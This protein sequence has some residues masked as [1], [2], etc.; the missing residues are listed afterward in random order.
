MY[1]ITRLLA[2][3]TKG[4]WWRRQRESEGDEV[5]DDGGRGGSTQ[6]I[7]E[8][9]A[10]NLRL[11]LTL[12]CRNLCELLTK[13]W[14]L[15]SLPYTLPR[16]GHPEPH[17]PSRLRWRVPLPCENQPSPSTNPASDTSWDPQRRRR[18][19]FLPRRECFSAR[20]CEWCFYV[21][22]YRWALLFFPTN[23]SQIKQ[24]INLRA[25]TTPGPS[26]N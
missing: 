18:R 26:R 10:R 4:R 25:V 16:A 6:F 20:E 1:N 8:S 19:S 15:F 11:L 9:T 2:K 24:V 22:W 13:E 23:L 7:K 21:C 5:G 3:G 14:R 12:G 17:L